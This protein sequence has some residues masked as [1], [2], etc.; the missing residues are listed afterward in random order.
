MSGWCVGNCFKLSARERLF[1]MLAASLADLDGLGILV[2]K[3]LYWDYHHKLCHNLPFALV[4]SIVLA[5][6]SPSR[7]RSFFIYL[8]LFHLHL[9]MDYFGSGPDWEIY[10]L[11]PF[12]QWSVI[13]PKAW[14]FYSWQNMSFAAGFLIWTIVIAIR[15]GRT[16]LETIMP[17]LD[18]QLVDWLRRR[19]GWVKSSAG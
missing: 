15:A 9:V 6:F 16:P 5:V 2:S 1:C 14:E 18:T 8:G 4:G 17:S 3:E 7:L 13:N 19:L 10:Y 12:S 11:W